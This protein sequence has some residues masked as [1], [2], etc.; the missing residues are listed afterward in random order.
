MQKTSVLILISLVIFGAK[1][2]KTDSEIPY[3]PVD[4]TINI[5]QPSYFNLTAVSGHET[6]VGGSLGIVIYRKSFNEFV[7][8][9]RHVPYQVS[10]NCR[11]DVLDDDVT[12]EE[13]CSGSQWLII[14]GSVIKGPA[15]Q[16]LLQY[17]TSFNDPI[18]R[19]FN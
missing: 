19:I 5:N 1:C 17:S 2:R 12:L 4:I 16:P 7:A 13:P 10:S 3:T 8:L 6:V 11:V 18:L 15:V 14:D 9:E